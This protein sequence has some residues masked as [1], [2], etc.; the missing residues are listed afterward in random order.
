MPDPIKRSDFTEQLHTLFH[1]TGGDS[2]GTDLELEQVSAGPVY[3]RQEVFAL[4]F[5]GPGATPLEQKTYHL[6]H[7][8]LGEMDIFL[9]PVQFDGAAFYYEA[10]FNRLI[11]ADPSF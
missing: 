11:P 5:K 7:T 6:V 3:P 8:Q 4:L 9:V 2:G 1:L 10:V